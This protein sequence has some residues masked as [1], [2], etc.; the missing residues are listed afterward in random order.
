[1]GAEGAFKFSGAEDSQLCHR[2][3]LEQWFLFV[4]KASESPGELV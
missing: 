3:G 4:N 1:M 2:I